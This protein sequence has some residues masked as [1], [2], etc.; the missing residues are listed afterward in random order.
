MSTVRAIAATDAA[1]AASVEL[2]GDLDWIVMKAIDKDRTRRYASAAELA[3]DVR[4]HIEDQPVAPGPPGARYRTDKFVRRHRVGVAVAAAFVV[5]LVAFV[6]TIAVQARR[7]ARERDR[8]NLEAAA[9]KQV[10]DFLIGL[11]NVSNPSE[12]RGN[13]LTAREIHDLELARSIR[14]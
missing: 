13:S 14:S 4:R 5:V 3:A 1:K 11:F 8:A 12:A 9:A 2:R 6:V 7:V 10:L